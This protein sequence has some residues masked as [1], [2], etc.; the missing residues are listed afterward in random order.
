[1]RPLDCEDG[2]GRQ[3]FCQ[4]FAKLGKGVNR[5]LVVIILGTSFVCRYLF[6]LGK[7]MSLASVLCDSGHMSSL[8]EALLG[9]ASLCEAWKTAL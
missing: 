5:L 3:Q 4:E 1:V 2:N 7:K 8:A 9:N 6:P